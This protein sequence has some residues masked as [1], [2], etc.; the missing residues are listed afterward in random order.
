VKA[1][2]PSF[3]G[4]VAF[5][6]EADGDLLAVT[7]CLAAPDALIVLAPSMRDLA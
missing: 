2:Q 5:E 3:A 4:D 7:L 6:V 1:P